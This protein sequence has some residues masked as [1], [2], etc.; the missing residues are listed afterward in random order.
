VVN[1]GPAT[2]ISVEA[3]NLANGNYNNIVGDEQLSVSSGVSTISIGQN[4]VIVLR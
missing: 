4:S 1:K 3:L 2:S